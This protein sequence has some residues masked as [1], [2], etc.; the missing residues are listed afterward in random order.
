M[1]KK[2]R[3]TWR[4]FTLPALEILREYLLQQHLN[5]GLTDARQTKGRRGGATKA[6][7]LK[8]EDTLSFQL[9]VGR[10]F[11]PSEHSVTGTGVLFDESAFTAWVPPLEMT[12]TA[13]N[14]AGTRKS[15]CVFQM[16]SARITE[17]GF[18]FTR[19]TLRRSTPADL[20]LMQRYLARGVFDLQ[21]ARLA[22]NQSVPVGERIPYL[23][24]GLLMK[25]AQYAA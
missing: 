2:C 7:L 1:P 11:T 21:A 15:K 4:T 20:V 3:L 6:W 22:H 12:V 19:N 9:I 18:D 16:S 24:P 10:N 13:S 8:T 25:A 14:A 17:H 5:A 23:L